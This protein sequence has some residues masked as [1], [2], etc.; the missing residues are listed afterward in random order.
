MRL[1]ALRTL[2]QNLPTGEPSQTQDDT[3]TAGQKRSLDEDG[4][5]LDRMPPTK[6]IK[7]SIARGVDLTE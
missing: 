6:K 5:E 7:I 1:T 4:I 2:D 3:Q